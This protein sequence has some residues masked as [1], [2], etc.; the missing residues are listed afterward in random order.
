M[1]NYLRTFSYRD[2]LT[3]VLSGTLYLS[4][5][6]IG[7]YILIGHTVSE[8]ILVFALI[9]SWTLPPL[10]GDFFYKK[11]HKRGNTFF[12]RLVQGIISITILC[13]MLHSLL[14]F[15]D[16]FYKIGFYSNYLIFYIVYII[17]EL[18]LLPFYIAFKRPG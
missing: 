2:I 18:I 7:G 5:F 6:F 8:V 10:V 14:L 1:K 17:T 9:L 3:A 4:L 11:E 12:G 15:F 13:F 16:T